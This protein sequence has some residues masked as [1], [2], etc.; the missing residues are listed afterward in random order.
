M[1]ELTTSGTGWVHE[2]KTL[3][4]HFEAIACGTKRFELR[5]NDRGFGVGD[6]LR[7]REY[8][9]DAYT[10]REL[11]VRVTQILYEHDGLAPGYVCMSIEVL[12]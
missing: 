11:T 8:T 3:S 1:H 6:N 9:G 7:L 5:R 2:L 4:Q 12:P 10:E